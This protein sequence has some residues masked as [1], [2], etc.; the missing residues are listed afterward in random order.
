MA[1]FKK[2]QPI[3]YT[4]NEGDLFP[5]RRNAHF[6]AYAGQGM[7]RIWVFNVGRR[8]VQISAI[9]SREEVSA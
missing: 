9:Q 5:Q 8:L 2:N 7:A 6:Y 1:R 3:I 4:E